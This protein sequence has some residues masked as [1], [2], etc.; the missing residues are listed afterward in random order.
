MQA[1]YQFEDLIE[2]GRDVTQVEEEI[3]KTSQCSV[4]DGSWKPL[5]VGCLGNGYDVNL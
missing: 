1:G 4:S 2:E 5:F 3:I